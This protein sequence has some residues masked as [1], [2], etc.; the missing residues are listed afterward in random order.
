MEGKC[1]EKFVRMSPMKARKLAELIKGSNA[2]DAIALLEQMPNRAAV[3]FKKAIKSAVNNVVSQAGE[4]RV[5]EEDLYLKTI[6]VD[7]GSSKYL[8]RLRPRAMGRAD[9]IRHRTSHI[10]VVVSEKKEK[11]G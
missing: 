7:M 10:L 6:R 8:R 3:P 9:V 5:K 1:I 4:L 2:M 11:E